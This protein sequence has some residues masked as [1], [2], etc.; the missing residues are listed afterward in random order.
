MRCGGSVFAAALAIVLAAGAAAPVACAAGPGTPHFADADDRVVAMAGKAL[1]RSQCAGCHGRYLQ[2]QPSWQLNDAYASR[3]APAFDETGF[4]WQKSDDEL[5]RI[6]KYGSLGAK[7]PGAMPAFEHRLDDEQILA[8]IAFIK[9]RWPL[10]LR[11]L[12]ATRNPGLA[13]MPVGASGRDWQLPANCN[14]VLR[15]SEAGG[16]P[17]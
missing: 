16:P 10:G 6:I 5:F 7:P 15:R 17:K 3:R 2:G 9:A 12:Q 1:Y 14:A 8:I 4:I 11:I 13:G